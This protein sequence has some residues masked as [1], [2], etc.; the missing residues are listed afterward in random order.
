MKYT[1]FMIIVPLFRI[2][3]AVFIFMNIYVIVLVQKI[4]IQRQYVMRCAIWY[5][6][7]D[8]KNVKNTHGGVLILVKSA[9]NFTKINTPAWVLF[10]F[11]LIVQMIPNRSTHHM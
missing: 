2:L 9:W 3:V 8:L 7:Y 5:H 4:G 6:L 10:T 1:T 11:F